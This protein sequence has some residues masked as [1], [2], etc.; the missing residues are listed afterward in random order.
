MA[1]PFAQANDGKI[2]VRTT[3]EVVD[4]MQAHP[5]VTLEA[6]LG[7]VVMEYDAKLTP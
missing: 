7:S 4:F 2:F 5:E 6:A 1:E 3:K